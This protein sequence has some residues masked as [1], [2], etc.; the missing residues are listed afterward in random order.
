VELKDPDE[1]AI[2]TQQEKMMYAEKLKTEIFEHKHREEVYQ[3]KR[4]ELLEIENA[5]RYLQNNHADRATGPTEQKRKTQDIMI[6]SLESQVKDQKRKSRQLQAARA[7]LTDKNQACQE[8]IE[9]RKQELRDLADATA[10]QVELTHR[11]ERESEV[12][13][14]EQMRLLNEFEGEKERLFDL[15]DLKNETEA[16]V[17]DLLTRL[18]KT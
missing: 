4:R 15:R 10:E 3:A 6:E 16:Q 8:A 9:V 11:K 12:L 17:E 2:L 18:R 5:F 1:L 13:R 14:Q 7:D